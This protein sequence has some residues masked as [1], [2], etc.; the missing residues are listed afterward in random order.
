MGTF[1]LLQKVRNY[2]PVDITLKVRQIPQLSS[3]AMNSTSHSP[4]G[5]FVYATALQADSDVTFSLNMHFV[6]MEIPY[7]DSLLSVTENWA[8]LLLYC[9]CEE[10]W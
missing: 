4:V 8:L 1:T 6:S 7:R 2:W 10:V 5:L 3:L 9:D